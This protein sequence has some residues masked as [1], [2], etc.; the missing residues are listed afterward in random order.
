MFGDESQQVWSLRGFGSQ[1]KRVI[2][3]LGYSSEPIWHSYLVLAQVQTTGGLLP[4]TDS[5]PGPSE[6]F[7]ALAP[8]ERLTPI[9]AITACKCTFRPSIECATV[10]NICHDGVSANDVPP[11][12]SRMLAFAIWSW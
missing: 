4:G 11:P 8:N 1:L 9:V 12:T 7:S 10:R 3:A 2:H 6:A 5:P